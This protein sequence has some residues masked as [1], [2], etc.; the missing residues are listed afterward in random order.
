MAAAIGSRT[1]ALWLMA[2]AIA[3]P[4]AGWLTGCAIHNL[5]FYLDKLPLSNTLISTLK[6]SRRVD[7]KLFY[8]YT[9]VKS[10]LQAGDFWQ[11]LLRPPKERRNYSGKKPSDLS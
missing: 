9:Q 2:A 11:I 1:I 5:L 8:C 7:N 10:A 3:P 6:R 4:A